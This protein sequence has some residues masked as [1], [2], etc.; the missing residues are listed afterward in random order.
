MSSASLLAEM[1][2]KMASI[3]FLV[4]PAVPRRRERKILR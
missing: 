2:K 4:H 3:L 1:K